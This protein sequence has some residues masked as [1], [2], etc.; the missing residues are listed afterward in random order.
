MKHLIGRT[1]LFLIFVIGSPVL[2]FITLC[3]EGH[4]EA[5]KYVK[6]ILYDI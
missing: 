3:I 6:Y 2:Y 1:I 5:I 4:D